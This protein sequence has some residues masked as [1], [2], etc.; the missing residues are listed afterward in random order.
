MIMG[1]IQQMH[2]KYRLNGVLANILVIR[3]RFSVVKSTVIFDFCINFD[4]DIL[5]LFICLIH[6]IVLGIIQTKHQTLAQLQFDTP[7]NFGY[8]IAI[9][10]QVKYS[11]A[12]DTP[13]NFRY[14][15]ATLEQSIYMSSFDTPYNS[16]YHIAPS[17]VCSM[18]KMFDTPYDS[19]I[20]QRSDGKDTAMKSLIHHI[21]LGII[22][23]C[24]VILSDSFV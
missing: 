1:I 4:C 9:K 6:Y 21:I 23:H 16:G 8:Y 18:D 12:F 19:G 10:Y 24:I 13:Y 7:Y 2:Q 5:I 20:I 15:I 11:Q 14:H 17:F 3:F 22:Q